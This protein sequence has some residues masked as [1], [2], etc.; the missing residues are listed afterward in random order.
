MSKRV[1]YTYLAQNNIKQLDES[2]LSNIDN[3]RI[4]LFC[5]DDLESKIMIK[6]FA[7]VAQQVT[8]I[9]YGLVFSNCRKTPSV[10]AYIEGKPIA[11]YNNNTSVSELI[12]W[13]YDIACQLDYYL[14]K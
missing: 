6:S 1:I 10:V 13:S 5:G 2:E 4:I 14:N 3:S 8:S 12:T 9:G 11:S 7:F